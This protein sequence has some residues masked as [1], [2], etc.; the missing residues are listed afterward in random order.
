MAIAGLLA[1][2]AK[3]VAKNVAKDKAKSFITG[4]KKTVK[5]AAIKKGG[6]GEETPGERGGALAVRP[7][8]SLVPAPVNADVITPISGAEMASTK[9]S[10]E[11]TINVIRIKVIEID[12]VLKGTL[13]QQKAASKKDKKSDEK[14]RRKKQE[15]LLEKVDTGKKDSGIKKLMA[16]AKGLFGGIF[17]FLKNILIGRLLVLLLEKRPNLP[18][19]NLLMF[20]AGTAEKIIDTIIGV[21]DAIGSFLAWGQE[22]LD[23]IRA[24]LVSDKGEEAGERFDGLLS[25]LTNLFNATVIVGSVFGALGAGAGKGK[26]KPGKGKDPNKGNKGTKGKVKPDKKTRTRRASKEARKRY[27]RRFGKD[28]AKQRFAG[29]TRGPIKGSL[30]R[31]GLGKAPARAALKTLGKG[32]V[33]AM[34]G[35]AKGFSRIPIVGPLIVAVS[36]L[37]AGEPL[38]QAAFKGV[39]AAIGGLLGSFIPIP[40]IGTLLGEAAGVFVGDLLYSLMLGGGPEEAKQKFMNALQTALDAGGLILKFVG[41]GFKKFTNKFFE[42]N[43]IEIEEGMGRR[44]AATKIVEVL[45]MKDFLEDRNYLENDQVAK[46]PNIMN[47]LNPLVSV[48]MMANS[49]F[50]D[51]FSGTSSGGTSPTS[52]STPI[53]ASASGSVDESS[54][55]PMETNASVAGATGKGMRTGPAGYDRIGAGAAYHVDTKFHKSIGMGGMIAAMDKLADE[56]TARGKEIVFSGQGYAR[57]KAYKSNLSSDEKRKLMQ[58]AIDAHSHSSFMRAEGF[59]PFDYYI[60]DISANKDLYHPSTEGAEILLPD[61][62]GEIKVGAHYGGYGKS[63]NIFDTSGKMVAM[64]GHGD[65]AYRLGGFTK[66]MAHRAV[67]GEEGREFVIDADS[68]AAIEDAFP[69]LLSEANLAKGSSAIGALMAY[70]SYEEPASDELVMVGGSGGGS[71]YGETPS[72]MPDPTIPSSSDT[73]QSWKDI[74]YKFG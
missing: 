2:A 42:T 14:Q 40:V 43:P 21:I 64:T 38:G 30:T 13:A 17:D 3:G 50:G 46:F 59:L 16:P 62:G 66:A 69:G 19:G 15:K 71:S 29:Q 20:L 25:A 54:Q 60:P 23:G 48:P 4:R 12:K 47:L 27:A 73:D 44:T 57:L 70:T 24:S 5:P 51:M 39:G 63:A 31:R 28:A 56:Y 18:G 68:T 41:D 32:G 36:S 74:R 11:D 9:G 58:S 53:T 37:L 10:E 8:A 6:G 35:I 52:T 22:K 34:K 65:L 45:G 49:F 55:I 33:Q 1:G 72:A 67:L 7:Q 61:M 26:D